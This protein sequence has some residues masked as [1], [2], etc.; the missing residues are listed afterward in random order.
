MRWRQT[1][2]VPGVITALVLL[3][4]VAAGVLPPAWDLTRGRAFT[5]ATQT[6]NLLAGLAQPVEITV[7]SSREPRSTG[8]RAFQQAALMLR[9]LLDLY[10][11]TQPA[12]QVRELDPEESAEGRRLQQQ[13][14]DVAP[15]C[16]VL[17][18]GTGAAARHEVLHYRD[19]VE[20]R[21]TRGG[22]IAAVDFLGE[23]AI[24]AALVRLSSGRRQT[25]I[26][27]L[28]GHGELAPDDAEPHSR[29]GLGVLAGQLRDLDCDLRPLDLRAAPRVPGDVHLLLLAGPEQPFDAAEVAKLRAYLLHGG[30]ALLLFEFLRDPL[31]R[32]VALTGLEELLA[33]QGVVIGNDRVITQGFT[34]ELDVAS[35]ALPA[36][37]DHPLVR[38]LAPTSLTLF[39]CRSVS[40]VPSATRRLAT[41]A[42]P[43]LVSH[44]FPRAWAD[45]DLDARQSPQP[46]GR[47]DL[48][49][50][51]AMAL[52]VER[53]SATQIEPM[54]VVAGDAE[55]A[56]NR[57]L[58]GPNG[59]IG[60]SFLLSSVNWLRGR[61]DLLADIPPR[62]HEPLRL[63]G[64]A[65]AHRGLVWKSSLFLCALI[66]TAGATVWTLRR[67]G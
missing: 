67:V 26:Y 58:S 33:D 8:D 27:S 16:V 57:A 44:P 42:A 62:R 49:G 51:V 38:S 6:R 48:E 3:N 22:E 5:P 53:V 19:L 36:A 11:R 29:R 4:A 18:Y 7:L 32:Q 39:E 21:G 60:Y 25:I 61:K 52:A 14:P 37:G 43:V 15:P 12:V 34:G 24:T 40:A 50:P 35:P 23:A 65:D 28:I 17:V 46:G 1:A 64:D 47:H 63:A 2:V 56:A 54:L 59:R 41:R 20:V 31:T 45:G 9:E 13:Y 55:F 66:T 30:K 10:R